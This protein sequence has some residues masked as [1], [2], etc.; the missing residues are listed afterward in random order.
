MSNYT[1]SYLGMVGM[2]RGGRQGKGRIPLELMVIFTFF[3]P[4]DFPI[5]CLERLQSHP[6]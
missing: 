4:E 1:I 2:G 6:K 3:V 5:R